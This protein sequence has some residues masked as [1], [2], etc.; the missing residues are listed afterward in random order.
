M[1]IGIDFDNTIVSYDAVF[2]AAAIGRGWLAPD[3]VGTKRAV[4]DAVRLLPDGERK[5]MSLQGEVYGPRMAEAQPFAGIA[6]F[7]ARCRGAGL[8]VFIVSHKTERGHFDPTNTDLRQASRAWLSAQGLMGPGAA[9]PAENVSF[10]PTRD[11]KIKA[12]AALRCDVFIDD[13]E[14][15]LLDSGFPPSCRRILFTG[16]AVETPVLPFESRSDWHEIADA[17]F[18]N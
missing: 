9:I 2:S 12:I 13:L 15:V 17:L 10:H 8:D 7:L 11:E 5:W 18:G 4:R 6:E 3:F 14:E 1:R 16:A